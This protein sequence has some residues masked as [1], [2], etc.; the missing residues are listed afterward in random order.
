M[1]EYTKM[2]LAAIRRIPRAPKFL[3]RLIFGA[4]PAIFSD[5]SK[6]TVD[7]Y[8][9]G[10]KLAPIVARRIAGKVMEKTSWSSTDFEAPLVAPRDIYTE[11]DLEKR[12]PGEPDYEGMGIEDRRAAYLV[13]KTDEFTQMHDRLEEWMV[14]EQLFTGKLT[15]IGEGYSDE[16]DLNFTNV[17]TPDVPW[18][19]PT[20]MP[21][22]ELGA[23]K[24]D[25]ADVSGVAPN[26]CVM[27][28]DVYAAFMACPSVQAEYDKRNI[29][30][31]TLQPEMTPDGEVIAVGYIPRIDMW[32]Y[33][34][35]ASYTDANGVSQKFVPARKLSIFPS[36]DRNSFTMYYGACYDS[37]LKKS[38]RVDRYP[39][40][41][42]D[43]KANAEFYEL[44]SH[45]LPIL[46]EVDSWGTAEV[47]EAEEA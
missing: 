27:A 16:L 11:K 32:L 10:R 35:S 37:A 34:Y 7:I 14:S 41:F 38:F 33:V 2:M 13:L 17:F 22:D 6:C 5:T 30:P 20:A 45:P 46:G 26:V 29:I 8:K 9:G 23:W 25:V 21:I 19:D 39:R 36:A 12:L 40:F 15:L 3:R 31:G 44:Q 24:L 18:D 42:E 28:A 43:A 47:L 1:D 4:R